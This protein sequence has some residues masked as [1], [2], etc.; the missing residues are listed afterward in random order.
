MVNKPSISPVVSE[1]VQFSR[2]AS[3]YS[4]QLHLSEVLK[5]QELVE[6]WVRR[7]LTDTFSWK[8][9]S[10]DFEWSIYFEN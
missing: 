2:T 7:V 9:S 4:V 3:V 10:N 8:P 6:K 1:Q 5:I